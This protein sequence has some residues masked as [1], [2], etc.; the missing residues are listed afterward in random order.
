M[1]AWGEYDDQNDSVHDEWYDLYKLIE[2]I[3]IKEVEKIT[4]IVYD[5]VIKNKKKYDDYTHNNIASGL[6]FLSLKHMRG[7]EMSNDF[8]N[9]IS[10]IGKTI[11]KGKD[12]SMK[13]YK[14]K[15]PEKINKK[16]L[17][18]VNSS[19]NKDLRQML[20]ENNVA[21][22]FDPDS[23]INALKNQKKLVEEYLS[24]K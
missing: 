11:R 21:G 19:V 20:E 3:D 15:H 7:N 12:D 2:N 22:W 16:L 5:Y 6:F 24:S 4:K 13:D 18:L 17:K 10:E 8:G 1:G 9:R 23:R 14:I